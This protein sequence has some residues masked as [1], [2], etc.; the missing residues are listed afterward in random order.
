MSSVKGKK[1]LYET[2]TR[3]RKRKR[4]LISIFSVLNLVLRAAKKTGN[5]V[6]QQC[7]VCMSFCHICS[8][9]SLQLMLLL[10]LRREK[11][12]QRWWKMK[13]IQ[14]SKATYSSVQRRTQV[15]LIANENEWNI[16]RTPIDRLR[17]WTE[18]NNHQRQIQWIKSLF[19]EKKTNYYF[20]SITIFFLF[21]LKKKHHFSATDFVFESDTEFI[22]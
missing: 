13:F 2:R 20:Q 10:V 8:V 12:R 16:F 22:R 14:D 5:G 17:C 3:T 21:H 4:F 9:Q 15:D 19:V 1:R 7:T 11:D 18:R 6:R